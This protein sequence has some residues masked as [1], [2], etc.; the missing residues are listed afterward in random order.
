MFLKLKLLVI[1]SILF[2]KFL[3]AQTDS[4]NR[5]EFTPIAGIKVFTPNN[6]SIQGKTWG[7][8]LAY[9]FNMTDNKLD[10]IRILHISAI[11][12]V[13]SYRNMQSLTIDNNPASRGSLGDIYTLIGRLEIP[14]AKA[15]PVRLLFTPGFGFAWSTVN[16]FDNNNPLVSSHI[17][18]AAQ[19]GL[20]VF[21]AITPSTGLQAGIDLLHYSNSA[22]RVPNNGINAVNVS[23]GIVQNINQHG[24]PTPEHPYSYVYRNSFEIGWDIG[25]RGVFESRDVLYRADIYA[26]YIYRLNQV[27]NLKGGFDAG[28]YFTAYDSKNNDATFEGHASSYDKWR[29]GVSIGGDINLGRFAVMASYGYYLHFNGYYPT[30]T[31]WVP[32]I[33][34]NVLPWMAIQ[35]KSY[36]HSHEADYLGVGLLFRVH[37]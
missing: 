21:T 35:G 32:G 23:L 34:Y 33:K 15:G 19:A 3:Y 16:Y 29:V 20:K 6:Y 27:F 11:D 36:I 28:Y 7:G 17:N 18:M 37:S 12:I 8:E 30:K 13:G 1:V 22:M 31:Y 9:H 2:S 25:E 26:G 5:I 24:P 10:Y 4:S 14:L